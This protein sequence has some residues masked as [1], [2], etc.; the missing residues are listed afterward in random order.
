MKAD[1]L[2]ITEDMSNEGTGPLLGFALN[3]YGFLSDE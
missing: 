3:E 2:D 1:A